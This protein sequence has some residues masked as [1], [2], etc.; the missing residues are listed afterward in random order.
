MFRCTQCSHTQLKWSGQCPGCNAWNT[1]EE[2]ETAT[3]A[4]GTQKKVIGKKKEV[5]A[6]NPRSTSHTRL[7]VKSPELAGVLGGGLVRGS[8]TL[9][10]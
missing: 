9:L 7:A 1:L 6:L 4:R 10:S 5:I 2:Q 8:L 3:I